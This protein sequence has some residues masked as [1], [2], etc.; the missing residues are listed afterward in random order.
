MNMQSNDLAPTKDG[1]VRKKGF[2]LIE[3]LVVISII[4]ILAALLLPSL[5]RTKLASKGAICLDNIRQLAML[6]SHYQDDYQYFCPLAPLGPGDVDSI[7]WHGIKTANADYDRQGSLLASY[8][9]ALNIFDCPALTIA[10][11]SKGPARNSGG[12]GYSRFIGS[13][14]GTPP[15]TAASYQGGFPLKKL[16]KT[17]SQIIMFADAAC[18]ID[19]SGAIQASSPNGSIAEHYLLEQTNAGGGGAVNSAASM[20]F[21]HNGMMASVVWLDGHANTNKLE[22]TCPSSPTYATYYLGFFGSKTGNALFRPIP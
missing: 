8:C 3:L 4:G 7:R 15:N 14:T 19:S 22:Y 10:D 6:N 16:T 11:K 17:P 18:V 20:H 1:I 9:T 21:R 2:T 13:S 12:Y 5:M